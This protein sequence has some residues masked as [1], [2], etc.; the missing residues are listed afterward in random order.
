MCFLSDVMC[1]DVS[2]TGCQ[3]CYVH[4]ASATG[5]AAQLLRLVDERGYELFAD[6]LGKVSLHEFLRSSGRMDLEAKARF[7]LQIAQ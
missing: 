5:P 7:F 2:F 1:L 3:C 6:A 4:E